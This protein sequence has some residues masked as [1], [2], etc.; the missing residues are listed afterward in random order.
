MRRNR[1]PLVRLGQGEYGRDDNG[2][3][4][5]DAST[6]TAFGVLAIAALAVA[7]AVELC[8]R[9]AASGEA[10]VSATPAAVSAQG[11]AR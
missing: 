4:G 7:A 11:G 6:L 1:A 9:K 3:R 8:G 2:Q 5:G 10:S